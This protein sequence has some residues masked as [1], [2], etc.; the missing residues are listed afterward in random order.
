MSCSDEE[1]NSVEDMHC[2]LHKFNAMFC[3]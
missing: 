3:M 2:Y 1:H